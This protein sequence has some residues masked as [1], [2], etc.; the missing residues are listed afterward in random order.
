MII[1]LD[2]QANFPRSWANPVPRLGRDL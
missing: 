1:T 2:L